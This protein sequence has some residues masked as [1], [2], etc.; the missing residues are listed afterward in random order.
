MKVVVYGTSSSVG[1][2]R[3]VNEFTAIPNMNEQW[4]RIR[5]HFDGYEFTIVTTMGAASHL[6]DYDENKKEIAPDGVKLIVLLPT[7]D[8]DTYVETIRK[9]APSIAIAA[10]YFGGSVDWETLKD[11][12]IA[13][14]LKKVGIKAV[15]NSLFAA[16]TFF[17][18]WTT[19][20]VLTEKGF[21][22]AKATHIPAVYQKLAKEN[23]ALFSNVYLDLAFHRIREMEFPVIVKAA[24]ASGS[25]GI[26]VAKN[27]EEA[28]EDI[29]S[30]DDSS[31]L[32]IE[33]MLK[34]EQFGT[35]IHGTKGNYT[36]LPPFKCKLDERGVLDPQIKVKIGPITDEKYR[37]EE[38][39]S[40]LRR[41][42]EEMGIEGCAQVDLAFDGDKWSIIEVNPRISGMTAASAALESRYAL[43][44]VIESCLDEG[45][46]YDMP[47]ILEKCIS[48]GTIIESYDD[49]DKMKTEPH[50]K[51]MEKG[52]P[53][54]LNSDKKIYTANIILGG[55]E[56]Y[57]EMAQ[58]IERLHKFYPTVINELTV[59]YAKE[60]ANHN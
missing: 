29:L 20:N 13:E 25:S 10:S 38:L 26:F 8:T 36:I 11:A 21:P 35:E 32:I 5:K 45:I 54:F 18:K 60:I 46:N 30:R 41:L 7:A 37:I 52:S 56:N 15:S 44:V 14:E 28:K 55:F 49:I 50:V 58:E 51:Y 2:I 17:D 43:E 16:E 53:L 6:V 39:R 23:P 47:K 33:E 9:E 3:F 59:L 40:M 27:F 1:F 22:V 24:G 4:Q 57:A 48:F 31:D 12:L 19:H 42:A 34:G